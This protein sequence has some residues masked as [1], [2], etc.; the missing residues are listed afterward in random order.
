MAHFDDF[1]PLRAHRT[2][3]YGSLTVLE[4]ITKLHSSAKALNSGFG[5]VEND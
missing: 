5:F 1:S 3:V 2:D 4:R